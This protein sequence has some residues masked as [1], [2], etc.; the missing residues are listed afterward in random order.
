MFGLGVTELLI[1]LVAILVLF[2]AGKLPSVMGD[3]GKGLSEFKK[4]LAGLP[5]EEKEAPKA[6]AAPKVVKAT[7]AK[8]PAAKKAAPKKTAA[9]ATAK[10]ATATKKPAAKKTAAKKP[11][12]NKP[13]AK[14]S[15]KKTS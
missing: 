15:T 10:K 13:A 5:E 8:K 3:V 7:A 12:A 14:K 2:G 11:A 6:E 9:K 1:I 4:G